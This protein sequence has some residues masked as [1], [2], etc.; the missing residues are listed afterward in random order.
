MFAAFAS[1]LAAVP[2]YLKSYVSNPLTCSDLHFLLTVD[3]RQFHI[4]NLLKNLLSYHLSPAHV[5]FK[6][7]TLMEYYGSA[8][9]RSGTP[10]IFW[11][12]TIHVSILPQEIHCPSQWYQERGSINFYLS[13]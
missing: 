7:M 11:N 2:P 3:P 13:N 10:G 8:N 4:Q 1:V 5:Q 6:G 12:P 9:R